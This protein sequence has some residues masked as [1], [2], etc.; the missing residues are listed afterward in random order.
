MTTYR[1]ERYADCTHDEYKK[2]TKA[3][4]RTAAKLTKMIRTADRKEM[5]K[6]GRFKAYAL[7]V[8]STRDGM[9]RKITVRSNFVLGLFEKG[10]VVKGHPLLWIPFSTIPNALQ[11]SLRD[12]PQSLVRVDR[13]G[14][15][16]LLVKR[17]GGE[18]QLFGVPQAV[19]QDKTDFTEIGQEIMKRAPAMYAQ[20][21]EG[22]T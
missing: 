8:R 10:G 22:F 16:P 18:P 4:D 3:L 11:M 12:Y 17:G 13:P 15:V 20:E 6:A 19:F 21:L 7:S 2:M 1:S 9:D 14:K 5:K